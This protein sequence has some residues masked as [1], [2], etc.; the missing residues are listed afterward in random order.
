MCVAFG[1]VDRGMAKQILDLINWDAVIHQNAG[2]VMAQIMQPE[3]QQAR[4]P[5]AQT[6]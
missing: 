5:A 1:G 2:N 4:K 6:V 3:I